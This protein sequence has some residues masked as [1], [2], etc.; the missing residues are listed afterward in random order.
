MYILSCNELLKILQF[1]CLGR[2]SVFTGLQCGIIIGSCIW[3]KPINIQFFFHSFNPVKQEKIDNDGAGVF[4]RLVSGLKISHAMK[5]PE[6]IGRFSWVK[7]RSMERGL[8][9]KVWFE[10]GLID[11]LAGWR[12]KWKYFSFY[13]KGKIKRNVVFGN[14]ENLCR[15]ASPFRQKL[16]LF[17]SERTVRLH[18]A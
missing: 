2:Y 7:G 4:V 5:N 6:Y 16:W 13:F 10:N 17:F 11:L 8:E 1:E 3:K 15:L 9:G 14:G 18:K 12:V